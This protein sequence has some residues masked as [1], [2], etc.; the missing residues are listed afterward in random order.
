MKNKNKI[1]FIP[2]FAFNTANIKMT[3]AMEIYENQQIKMEIIDGIIHAHYKAG[4]KI[5]LPDA[6]TIVAERLKLLKSRVLPGL[7]LDG[8]VVSMDK[9]ARDYFSSQEG[10]QGLK[11]VAIVEN[12]FFSKMLINFFM[13][14][15]NA[16]IKV[17]A[18]SNEVEALEWLKKDA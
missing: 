5:T 11:S 16:S 6:K 13:R 14:I 17:K 2:I 7:V 1:H 18:F 8:G 12:S 10:I 4:L 9:A 15:T 3:K